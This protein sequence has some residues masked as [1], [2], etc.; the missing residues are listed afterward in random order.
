MAAPPVATPAPHKFTILAAASGAV[1]LVMLVRLVVFAQAPAPLPA[2]GWSVTPWNPFITRHACTT[3]YWRAATEIDRAPDVYAPSTYST[4]RV[5]PNGREV[6]LFIGPYAVDPYEYPPTFLLLPRLLARVTPNFPSFRLWW[7][8]VSTVTVFAGLVVIARRV[9]RE[10][11]TRSLWLVPLAIIPLGV[12]TTIQGGNAQLF[13]V[14][15]AMLAM[16]AFERGWAAAGGLL[17]GYA[18]IGKMF[19]ALLVLYLIVRRDWR[20]VAW[21]AGWAIGLTL[22]TIAEV[23]WAPFEAFR[24][25]LPKLLNGEAF[26]MLRMAGP[27]DISLSV[28]GL[29]LKLRRFGGPEVPIESLRIT[30]WIFSAVLLWATV[31]LAL[32]P[33]APR[34]APLAWL[35]V[36]GLAALRSP[37]LP[38]YGVFPAVW[39]ATILLALVW[40]DT[41]RRW[42]VLAL[43]VA[44]LWMTGGPQ[45]TPLW[46]IASATTLQIA[47]ILTLFAIAVRV[48]REVSV[49]AASAAGTAR[50]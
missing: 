8:L 40:T 38:G 25:H 13:F 15:I 29:I 19:P 24:D 21:T 6:P 35:V 9:D 12:F 42:P 16:L 33:V 20:A 22:L 48:G 14:V 5:D 44:L 23:G 18:V 49:P 11:G 45:S 31:R 50:S 43:W 27:S 10:N 46:V 32:R 3:A 37:F 39:I 1:L 26:P 36:L 17:L 41:R 30:G 7:G 47:A 4:G 34:L 2:I 28:P